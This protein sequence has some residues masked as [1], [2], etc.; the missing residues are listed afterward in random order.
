VQIASAAPA[1]RLLVFQKE[2]QPLPGTAKPVGVVGHEREVKGQ[3]YNG[4]DDIRLQALLPAHPSFDLAVNIITGQPGAAL[5][6]V[7][8]PVMERAWRVL[9]GQ[10]V[11]RLCADWHPVQV[12]DVIWTAPFC[13]QWFVA[14][15]RSPVSCICCQDVNRDPM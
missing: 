11:F 2:Y 7:Q 3:P 12:G 9:R 5:P 4:S 8:S 13:P 6:E 15:G 10:A 1:A 14:M